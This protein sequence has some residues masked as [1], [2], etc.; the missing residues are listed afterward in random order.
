MGL[1]DVTT[2]DVAASFI[3]VLF[4]PYN[5]D[6]TAT[7]G[8]CGLHDVHVLEVVDLSIEHE[9]LV[10]FWENIG[11]WC[12]IEC[13]AILPSHPLHV[14]PQLVLAANAPGACKMV[15]F[16]VA[17]K[18]LDSARF[19]KASP[20]HV[21]VRVLDVLETSHFERVYNAVVRVCRLRD[22]ECERQVWFQLLLVI[23][24]YP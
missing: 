24:D 20:A 7:A 12:N 23:L 8:R 14:A 21:P 17:V 3:Y 5:F 16:L 4:F 9:P 13:L 2:A 10:V 19:E 18:V 1:G 22:F 15:Y 6:S 11:R